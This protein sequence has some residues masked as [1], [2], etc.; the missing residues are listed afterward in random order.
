MNKDQKDGAGNQ[1]KG[2]FKEAVSKV[3]GNKAGEVEGKIQKAVGKVQT[4]VGNAVEEDKRNRQ[5]P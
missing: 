5:Q 2:G 3:T 1:V 4:K